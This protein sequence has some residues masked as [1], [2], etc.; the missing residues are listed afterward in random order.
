MIKKLIVLLIPFSAYPQLN[1]REERQ[2]NNMQFSTFSWENTYANQIHYNLSSNLANKKNVKAVVKQ[3]VNKR[4]KIKSTSYLNYNK[5]GKIICRAYESDSVFFSY[6]DTLLVAT[7]RDA[8]KDRFKTLY[9][10]DDQSRLVERQAYKNNQLVSRL[11]LG[12]FLDKKRSFVTQES[13]GRKKREFR[14]NY[15][16]DSLLN[17]LTKSEFLVDGTVKRVWIYECNDRGKAVDPKLEAMSSSCRYEQANND[18]SYSVFNRTLQDGKFIL[19]ETMFTKDSV[20]CGFRRFENDSIL[21]YE[22]LEKGNTTESRNFSKKGKFR[23]KSINT[24]N[25]EGNPIVREYQNKRGK[26]LSRLEFTYD[27]RGLPILLTTSHGK[28]IT[29]FEYTFY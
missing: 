24:I 6:K 5:Q 9:Q 21:V 27:E 26:I 2:L 23:S 25:D 20:S 12:Y 7:Q 29:R 3:T 13:F 28:Q 14:M 11:T 17:Q 22:Q 1:N 8:K 16:Y 4:G 15:A 18:G 10:Y 19:F